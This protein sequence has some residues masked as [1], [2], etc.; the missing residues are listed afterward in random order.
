MKRPLGGCFRSASLGVLLI[1][2]GSALMGAAPVFLA[3][4][5]GREPPKPLLAMAGQRVELTLTLTAASELNPQLNADFVAIA[6]AIGAPVFS[7]KTLEVHRLGAAGPGVQ[8]FG[9]GLNI[10]ELKR[11]QAF[12][13]RLRVRETGGQAWLPLPV[14]RFEA[15]PRT[16]QDTLRQIQKDIPCGR[17]AGGKRLSQLC[18]EEAIEL[19]ETPTDAAV[20]DR[21]V[22]IWLAETSGDEVTLPEIPRGA[23]WLVFKKDIRGDIQVR[24]LTSRGPWCVLVDDS[25]LETINTD[26]AAQEIFER[27]LAMAQ[28]LASSEPQPISHEPPSP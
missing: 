12:L 6:G 10:P 20:A 11:R 5:A 19:P 13:L 17:L 3:V 16:W 24:R 26:P 28:T 7:G 23:L 21:S 1:L 14:A 18:Q 27:A 25:V 15:V 4:E 22:G 2:G 9:F 8:R